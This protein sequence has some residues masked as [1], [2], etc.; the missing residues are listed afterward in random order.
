[1]NS[2]RWP[3][4]TPLFFRP[5]GTAHVDLNRDLLFLGFR[6]KFKENI[7]ISFKY[8]IRSSGRSRHLSFCVRA[9]PRMRI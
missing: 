3:L 1:M 5:R 6:S 7:N 4:P 8:G 2:L 9:G